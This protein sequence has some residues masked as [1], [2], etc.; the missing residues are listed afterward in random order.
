LHDDHVA[1]GVV[2]EPDMLEDAHVCKTQ[3]LV[4]GDR[5]RIAGIANDGDHLAFALRFARRYQGLEQRPADAASLRPVRHID[6]VLDRVLIGWAWP[7]G[8]GIGII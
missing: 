8:A 5:R 1:P 6:G 7:V 4:Q 3:G 2:F